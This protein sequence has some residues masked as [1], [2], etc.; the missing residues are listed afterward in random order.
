[1]P[2]ESVETHG[3]GWPSGIILQCQ[4]GRRHNSDYPSAVLAFADF[5]PTNFQTLMKTLQ[6]PNDWATI[7]GSVTGWKRH[8]TPETTLSV[9]YARFARGNSRVGE[10]LETWGARNVYNYPLLLSRGSRPEDPVV[11]SE[12]DVFYP[13][14]RRCC[15]WL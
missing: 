13:V 6:T 11:I 9:L 12:W 8:A 1:M 3:A 5:T 2:R 14:F 7:C 4:Y 10:D 15:A